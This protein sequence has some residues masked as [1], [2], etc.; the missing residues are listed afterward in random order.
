MD[1]TCPLCGAPATPEAALAP[2]VLVRC[3]SCGFLFR[4]DLADA[5]ATRHLYEGGEYETRDFARDYADAASLAERRRNA[6]TRVA[7]VREHAPGGRL[8]DAGAAGGAFVLEARAAGFAAQGI[9]PA[10]A[11]A[12]HA[13]EAV[14]VDVRDGRLE[15]LAGTDE[16]WDVVTMWH[17][18]EHVPDPVAALRIV[19]DVLAPGGA[20]VLEVP[21][22]AS[23]AARMLGASWTHLDAEAH[24]SHF[25]PATLRLALERAGLQVAWM[26]TVAHDVYLRGRE[27]VA[28]R[29]LA[30]RLKLAAR[31]GALGSRDPTRH[32]YLRAV[33]RR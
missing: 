15:D 19:R 28:P 27:R 29:A 30:H 6:A 17:V 18:L 9:E 23:T 5:E 21:N 1:P 33:A 11:F 24:V 26:G 16:T 25:A 4:P 12:R 3:T 20:V 13:R 14:G 31:G 10:P 22:V 8:L 2:L 32:E 7:F